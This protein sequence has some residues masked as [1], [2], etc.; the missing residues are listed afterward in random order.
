M[1]LPTRCSRRGMPTASTCWF[2]ASTT[3]GLGS[4]WLDMTS[5]DREET[6]GLYFA[7]L[8]KGEPSPL[9][10]ES[11]EDPG[12]GSAPPGGGARVGPPAGTGHRRDRL[13]IRPRAR[14]PRAPVTVQIDFDGLPQ[15]IVSVPGVPERQIQ[16]AQG[17]RAGNCLLPRSRRRRRPRRSWWRC[18]PAPLSS[19]RS[20]CRGVCNRRR[21]STTSAPMAASSSI[22]P[23][24]A[25]AAAAAVRPPDGLNLFLVDAD[26]TPPAAAQGRLDVSLRMYLEPREEFKQIFAEGWRNQRDYLYVTN[27]HGANWTQMK[28]MYGELLPYVESPRRSQLSARQH[29]RRDCRRPLVRPR[30]R[31]ARRAAIARRSARC[32]LR[33]REWPLQDR[34]HLRQR[35]LEP[36]LARAALGARR[37]RRRS[38]ISSSPSTASSCGRRTISIACS[39]AP[40]TGRPCS[41]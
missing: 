39:T 17:G 3:F 28:E 9:L 11:D 29:G 10:P 21:S 22:A 18:D 2:L 32:R 14:T 27:A 38:A 26:R 7:V 5:Y 13:A 36:R 20:S 12:V 35:E 23:A 41:A 1:A 37:R 15:R 40:P 4:Q 34:A 24:A 33:R 25:P 8:K 19:E 30:R 16:P 6:F 31:H